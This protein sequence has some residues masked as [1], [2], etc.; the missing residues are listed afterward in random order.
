MFWSAKDGDDAAHTVEGSGGMGT[1]IR[2]L[3]DT[4]LNDGR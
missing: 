4:G 2:G 3:V 1:V